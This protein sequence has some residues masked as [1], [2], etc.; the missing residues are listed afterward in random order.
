MC[1]ICIEVAKGSMSTREARRALGEMREK[2]G[3]EHAR[4]VESMLDDKAERDA[5][6]GTPS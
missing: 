4:E 1:L 2:V 3:G 5:N 6:P